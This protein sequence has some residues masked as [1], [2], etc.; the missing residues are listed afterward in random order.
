MPNDS[1][2]LLVALA[3]I[4]TKLDAAIKTDGD[5]EARLRA[6]ETKGYVTARQLWAGML[7]SAAV[8]SA[9]ITTTAF[10]TK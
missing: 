4:E 8:S 1:L 9:V 3:R 2:D 6:V 10:L 7:G 5:H